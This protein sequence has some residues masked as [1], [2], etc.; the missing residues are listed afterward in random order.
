[1][2]APTAPTTAAHLPPN[3]ATAPTQRTN[4]SATSVFGRSVRTGIQAAATATGTNPNSAQTALRE[5]NR[6]SL[7]LVIVGSAGGPVAPPSGCAR[8]W[9][10]PGGVVAGSGEGSD[11]GVLTPGQGLSARIGPLELRFLYGSLRAER[12]QRGSAYRRCQPG[13]DRAPL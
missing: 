8:F 6:R 3:I 11:V 9:L 2:A 10:V 13:S 1:M 4:N 12:R 5:A 7:I